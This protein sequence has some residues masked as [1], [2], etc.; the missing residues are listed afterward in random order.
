VR[1]G[2]EVN[3][4]DVAGQT[5]RR[6][7]RAGSPSDLQAYRMRVRRDCSRQYR[8]PPGGQNQSVWECLCWLIPH[9]MHSD[10]RLAAVRGGQRN[11]ASVNRQ[12]GNRLFAAAIFVVAITFW[13]GRVKVQVRRFRLPL[14]SSL[15]RCR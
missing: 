4:R 1:K 7:C 12:T 2:C 14:H 8:L 13:W 9:Q 11:V 3:D 15:Q 10:Q 6:G 5:A